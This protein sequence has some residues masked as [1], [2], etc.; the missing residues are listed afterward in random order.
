MTHIIAWSKAIIAAALGG[1][2]VLFIL[3]N[4]ETVQVTFLFWSLTAP[5]AAILSAVFAVGVLFGL[6]LTR[7]F[8]RAVTKRNK[9]STA[10]A[11]EKPGQSKTDTQSMQ[12][13]RSV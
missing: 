4:M 8:G 5:R 6:L 3:Q 10:T 2:F 9:A 1:S 7:R 11:K 12:A 13:G